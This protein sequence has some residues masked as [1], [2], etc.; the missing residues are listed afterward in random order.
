M[1]KNI[2]LFQYQSKKE[3]DSGKIITQKPNFFDSFR[4][5]SR[6]LSALVDNLS[7]ID[8]KKCRDKNCKSACDSK[9]AKNNKPSY[10]CK[11]VQ[12]KAIKANKWIN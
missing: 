10:N 11:R 12:K 1:L 7:E 9:G 2:L 3:L 6:S 8:S 5:L 4:F